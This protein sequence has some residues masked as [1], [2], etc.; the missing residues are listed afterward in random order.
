MT[1]LNNQ[2]EKKLNN[3]LPA[4]EDLVAKCQ[5]SIKDKW[6][7]LKYKKISSSL[8]SMTKDTILMANGNNNNETRLKLI[9][10]C[11]NKIEN[12]LDYVINCELEQ[13]KINFLDKSIR[14]LEI[15]LLRLENS[16]FLSADNIKK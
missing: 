13:D 2:F 5:M 11:R 4:L 12:V 1:L 14:L 6:Q 10:D 8:E 3:K 16:I 9:F 7:D 15:T